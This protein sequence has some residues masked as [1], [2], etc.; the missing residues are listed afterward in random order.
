MKPQQMPNHVATDFAMPV[1]AMQTPLQVHQS[2]G[3]RASPIGVQL[4]PTR[5]SL[6]PKHAALA[7]RLNM[8]IAQSSESRGLVG[9]MHLK[10]A[11]WA[12]FVWATLAIPLF[13]TERHIMF[14]VWVH[15]VW[16]L[17]IYDACR[18]VGMARRSDFRPLH[19]QSN[20][21]FRLLMLVTFVRYRIM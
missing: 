9:R 14:W 8:M 2:R 12:I 13:A 4:L 1:L 16:P 7:M 15:H 3:E 19:L 5:F 6:G 20:E 18:D 11:I 17:C 21:M 10:G